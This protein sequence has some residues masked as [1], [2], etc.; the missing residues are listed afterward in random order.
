MDSIV[1][2]TSFSGIVGHVPHKLSWTVW[3]FLLLGGQ[4]HVTCKMAGK[5]KLGNGLEVLCIYRF[6]GAKKLVSGIEEILY[7]KQHNLW[8]ASSSVEV[9]VI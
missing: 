2:R 9:L 4:V 8:H 3:H 5:R 6:I 1:G 7:K